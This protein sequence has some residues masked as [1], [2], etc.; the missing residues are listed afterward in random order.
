MYEADVP[1]D[2]LMYAEAMYDVFH[3]NKKKMFGNMDW[4]ST[5]YLK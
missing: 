4:W 5:S 2:R 1:E 3:V